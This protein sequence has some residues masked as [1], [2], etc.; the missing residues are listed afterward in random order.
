M[1]TRRR[2]RCRRSNGEGSGPCPSSQVSDPLRPPATVT[3]STPYARSVS[4]VLLRFLLN[5]IR[6]PFRFVLCFLNWPLCIFLHEFHVACSLA[7]L[8]SKEEEDS[9]HLAGHR[10][11][12]PI[13]E[14]Q[15]QMFFFFL[16]NFQL[17]SLHVH[18]R[19]LLVLHCCYGSKRCICEHVDGQCHTLHASPCTYGSL[20]FGAV[21]VVFLWVNQS[22]LID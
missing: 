16:S 9:Q 19:H 5:S 10:A 1:P 4:V 21:F 15:H 18:A 22:I 2:P 8:P 17:R 11:G 12:P 20:P 14:Q 13:A 7:A 6:S 3:V